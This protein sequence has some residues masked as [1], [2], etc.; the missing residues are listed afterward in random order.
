MS[1]FNDFFVSLFHE[2]VS[3]IPIPKYF[4]DL[5]VSRTKL[6]SLILEISWWCWLAERTKK[7]LGSLFI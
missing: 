4:I 1:F 7:L 6:L 2:N 3:S 5:T